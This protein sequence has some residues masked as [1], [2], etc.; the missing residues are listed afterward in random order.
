MN[1]IHIA[2]VG[3]GNRVKELKTV[4]FRNAFFSLLGAARIASMAP[5]VSKSLIFSFTLSVVAS[6]LSDSGEELDFK[7]PDLSSPSSEMF[8]TDTSCNQLPLTS[9]SSIHSLE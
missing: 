9:K 3:A 8:F 4:I 6:N 1:R 7:G 5:S 2:T